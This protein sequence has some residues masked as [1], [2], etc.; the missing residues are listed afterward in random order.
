MC[1]I[2]HAPDAGNADGTQNYQRPEMKEET[3]YGSHSVRIDHNLTNAQRMYG[4]VSWYDRNSN[5]NNYFDNISTGQWFRFVSRQAVFDHVW[6]M[7]QTTVL[8]VRY[9]YDRFLRGP[10]QPGNHGMDHHVSPRVNDHPVDIRV[11]ASDIT[12]NVSRLVRSFSENQTAMGVVN[13]TMGAQIDPD[14]RVAYREQ[15]SSATTR[16]ASSIWHDWTRG[17]WTTRYRP[18][19]GQSFAA[20]LLGPGAAACQPRLTRSRRISLRPDDWRVGSLTSTSA[21]GMS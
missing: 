16:P 5:Y 12:G 3:E 17:R 10:G 21:C 1:W 9:G 19:P 13:K 6:T 20:F 8:N 15:R 11:P 18:A 7:N 14:H 4:R 2:H